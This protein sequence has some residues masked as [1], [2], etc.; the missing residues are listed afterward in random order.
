MQ[1]PTLNPAFVVFES[2]ASTALECLATPDLGDERVHTARKALK[3]ARAALRLLR[4][5]LDE[6]AYRAH[7]RALRDAGRCL[8]PLRDAHALRVLL[9]DCEAQDPPSRRVVA[10]LHAALDAELRRRRE[11]LVDTAQ[12]RRCAALIEH[13]RN[14]MSRRDIAQ[15][16]VRSLRRALRA[17]YRRARKAFVAARRAPATEMLHEWR[18]QT[19]YLRT[20]AQ[21]LADAGVRGLRK[22]VARAA[23]IAELLG[24]EHDLSVLRGLIDEHG[25]QAESA[26]LVGRIA[27][28][29][30]K[31]QKR[32]LELGSR[33]FE[34]RAGDFGPAPVRFA[35]LRETT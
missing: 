9:D 1:A 6:D 14:G 3:K 10:A 18:K 5:V 8:S 7:N 33:L 27:R 2:S 21:I 15:A 34:T 35:R 19:K 13:C 23:R 24:D 17:I 20:A 22:T 4:P 26:T 28:Y 25:L 11:A 31:L 12:R 32:A 29:R 30:A 16:G